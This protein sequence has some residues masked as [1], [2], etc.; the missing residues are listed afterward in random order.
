MI[1]H[2]Y[3]EWWSSP[4]VLFWSCFVWEILVKVFQE[5]LKVCSDRL[6]PY[7]N[8]QFF[9]LHEFVQLRKHINPS[10]FNS[11]NPAHEFSREVVDFIIQRHDACVFTLQWHIKSIQ[12]FKYARICLPVR[13]NEVLSELGPTLHQKQAHFIPQRMKVAEHIPS[14]KPP[15]FCS[16]PNPVP[17]RAWQIV[18]KIQCVNLREAPPVRPF[19]TPSIAPAPS[20]HTLMHSSQDSPSPFTLSS[21]FVKM[22]L[23]VHVPFSKLQN[24]MSSLSFLSKLY[25]TNTSSW[26]EFDDLWFRLTVKCTF[27]PFFTMSTSWHFMSWAMAEMR[28]GNWF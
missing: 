7:V 2:R 25:L 17:Y 12:F 6:L 21:N 4:V 15:D 28:R 16:A 19:F 18:C 26:A 10:H 9:F 27:S 14:R 20:V 11:L 8:T 5:G 23:P 1:C 24:S 13:I 3:S 22:S